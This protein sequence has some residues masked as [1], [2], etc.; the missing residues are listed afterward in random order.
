MKVI[1]LTQADERYIQW[2]LHESGISC[3]QISKDTGIS[4]ST[5]SRIKSGKTPMASIQFG[6]AS[7]LTDYAK[8]LKGG[9]SSEEGGT[10]E[11]P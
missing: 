2:L 9:S 5:L 7:L 3:Y 11:T 1:L 8:R 10:I 4:E 6:Y